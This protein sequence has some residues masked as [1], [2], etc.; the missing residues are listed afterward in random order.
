MNQNPISIPTK[1]L[2]ASI[3]TTDMAF[4][5]NNIL[6]W[7]N[8]N[9]LQASDFGT[10]GRGVFRNS[11]NSQIEFF[12]FDPSTIAS[13]TIT[14]LTRGNDYSGGTVDGAK[15]KYN[16]P[17][18]TT[19]V[20]LGS[21]PPALLEDYMDK[22]SN[23]TVGGIKT[24]TS[25]PVVPTPTNP[26]DAGNKAYIDNGLLQGAADASTTV[27]GIA[28]LAQSPNST[29]GT[30]TITIASP[31]VI[32]FN[33]HG[34]TA[35]DSVQFTTSGA[36][37]TG[38]T[39]S[40]TYYVIAAGL[41]TNTFE[42]SATFGGTAINTSGS[43]SGTQTLIKVTPVAVGD[44]DN[45]I[46]TAGQILAAVGNNTDIA[47]GSGNKNVTQTGLQH[48]AENYAADSSVSANTITVTLSPVPTSYS[49]G[50]PIRVKVANATT[51]ATTINVNSLGAKTVK[52]YIAGA[53]ADLTT[54]D[55][56]ANQTVAMIYD[57]TNFIL[58]ATQQPA[59]FTGFG[60]WT[61]ATADG[62]AHQ[63]TTDCL[64]VMYGGSGSTF[65]GTAVYTDSANPPTTQRGVITAVNNLGSSSIVVPVKKNDFYKIVQ[66]GSPAGGTSFFY[67][68]PIS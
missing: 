6:S 60:T 61:A 47:V 48:S 46:G 67:L 13:A 40:T 64:L 55:I 17:Q 18:G 15:T 16:W 20:D 8:L 4:T 41:A 52:K 24:F 34:L 1:R 12:T 58:Q 35:G 45:R 63:V 5:L 28:R 25:S 59:Y 37:P 27:K 3:L 26:T 19:Y 36:L 62:A 30:C 50:M 56:I 39:A 43:Q 66:T 68:I 9:N 54:G 32:T 42:I 44:N 29:K 10:Y 23:E 51:G 2:A 57:G 33:S 7:D 53:Q 49:A 11:S 65:G 22:T 31:A 38:I 21:N 14:I